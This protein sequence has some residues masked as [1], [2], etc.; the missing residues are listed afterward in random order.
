[1]LSFRG[2]PLSVC[3]AEAG[4]GSNSIIKEGKKSLLRRCWFKYPAP[5]MAHLPLLP[6]P[7]LAQAEGAAPR[8]L[9]PLPSPGEQLLISGSDLG[10]LEGKARGCKGGQN[11][12]TL[13]RL[14]ET[15]LGLDGL[16][17][18]GIH[19]DSQIGPKSITWMTSPKHTSKQMVQLRVGK[20]GVRSKTQ[21]FQTHM[22][23]GGPTRTQPAPQTPLWWPP[24]TRRRGWHMQDV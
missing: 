11:D 8:C 12:S 23:K 18:G 14:L 19:R 13:S 1:M 24:L 21:T 9:L 22:D 17:A 10:D 2:I 15:N 3:L 6:S 4:E 7:S 20:G 5:A 16:R